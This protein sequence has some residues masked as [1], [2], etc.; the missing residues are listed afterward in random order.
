[1]KNLIVS[2][3]VTFVLVSCQKKEEVIPAD[4]V[5]ISGLIANKKENSI[6]IIGRGN[7]E[8]IFI[9]PDG[10]F[11]KTFK[12]KNRGY[13]T[14]YDG[15]N[16]LMIYL[17]GGD[18]INILYDYENPDELLEFKGKGAETNNFLVQK[19][20]FERQN[21]FYNTKKLYA[22]KE[23]DFNNKLEFYKKEI[24]KMLSNNKIDSLIKTR[25]E[26][27]YSRI[28]SKMKDGYQN[29]NLSKQVAVKGKP[30]PTFEF[31]NYKG[32]TTSL[33]DLKGYYVY[34]DVWATWCGPCKQQIPFL[35]KL[36]E[37]FKN[38]PIKFVSISV[39]DARRNGGSW[40]KARTKWRKFVKDNKLGG[41]QLF[42]DKGW[43]SD[44]IKLYGIRGI[45]RFILIDKEGKIINPN[46]PRP[47]QKITKT[48]LN[49]LK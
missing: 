19:N 39:D 11:S 12:L 44:F 31:E 46:A 4:S 13:Y 45:P 6:E 41:I 43:Q 36:E 21:E 20:K 40:D 16:K 42:A 7:K 48:I 35:K 34:I 8:I 23:S 9:N 49:S 2:L 47:S 10:T 15:K 33:E 18:N 38:K 22:L 37:K 30:S 24:D 3:I 5:K 27:E 1:M 26:K 28:L 29:V 14:L 32:G 25:F 17:N